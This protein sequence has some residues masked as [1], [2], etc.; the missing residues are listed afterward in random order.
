MIERI[1]ACG[2]H[3]GP[4]LSGVLL[5]WSFPTYHCFVLAWAALIP[6]L[7]T[8]V[9]C[10]AP[11]RGGVCFF[12]AGW[13]F[14]SLLLQWLMSNIYWGG[15]WAVIGYQLLCIALAL[16]WAIVGVLWLWMRQRTPFAGAIALAV[17]WVWMEW[18]QANLFSGFGWSALGYCQG[19]DPALAQCAALGGVSAVSFLLVAFNALLAL[20]VTERRWRMARSSAAVIILAAGHLAG[21][22]L[23]GQAD[24]ASKPFTAGLFQSNFPQEMKWDRD[25]TRDMVVKAAEHSQVLAEQHPVQCFFWPEALVMSDFSSPELMQPMADLVRQTGAYL[26]TGATRDAEVQ[27]AV[28][29]YNSSLL[30]TPEGAV[31]GY[32]DKVHLA[33]FGEYMPFSNIF[34]FLRHITPIDVDAGTEQKVMTLGERRLGPLICFEVL[35]APLVENLRRMGADTLVV[36][37]NLGWFGRSNAIPQELELARFRAIESRLPLIHVAN[38]GISGVFD[39]WGRFESVNA[40]L[41]QGRYHEWPKDRI[42]DP[43]MFIMERCMGAIKVALPAPRPL[44]G[45]PAVFPWMCSGIALLLITSAFLKLGL[46]TSTTPEPQGA[47]KGKSTKKRS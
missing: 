12:A 28:R 5:A 4:L 38:S 21:A 22:M 13:M 3:A 39:P 27:G 9:K 17:L 31:A 42:E 30:L 10:S 7:L 32:Y 6:L 19:K 23:L 2:G 29:S 11:W 8:A 14:H 24:Y 1:R 44:P 36:V 18:C 34:P 41:Y 35:F 37:T 40:M 47:S 45:G 25:Y 46:P 15:G 43:A 20:A 16:C 33:P 26:F